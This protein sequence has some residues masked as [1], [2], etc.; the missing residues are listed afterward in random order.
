MKNAQTWRC[1]PSVA[2]ANRIGWLFSSR[3]LVFSWVG[4]IGVFVENHLFIQTANSEIRWPFTE[5]FRSGVHENTSRQLNGLAVTKKYITP[6][7]HIVT[8]VSPSKEA[9]QNPATAT[10]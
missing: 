5:R 2:L 4:C 3:D 6:A 1:L 9:L 7:R 10:W 8:F